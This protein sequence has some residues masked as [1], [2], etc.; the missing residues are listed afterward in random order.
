MLKTLIRGA[1]AACVMAAVAA[2]ASAEEKVNYMLPAPAVLPAFA[3][4]MLAKYLG[5]Y[6]AEGFDV[7]FQLGR[8]GLDVGRQVGVGN[9]PVGGGLGDTPIL[10]R[11]SGVPV[12]AVAVL[13]GGAM[14]VIV[15]RADRGIKTL[16][17]LKGKAI[18][19]LSFQDTT[20]FA[21]LGSLASV[22]LGSDDLH[23]QAVGP[24]GTPGLVIAGKADAC[25]CVP[26]WEIMVK[27]ALDGK[28]V[29]MPSLQYFPS[30]AQAILASDDLIK[31]QPKLVAGL[32]RATLKGMKYIMDDPDKAAA[33]YVKAVP[34]HAGKEKLMAEI[35]RNFVERTY[36]GQKTLGMIDPKRMAA[37]QD[38]YLKKKIISKATPIADLYTNDFVK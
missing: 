9:V 16:K 35:L 33:D 20:Y 26:D 6:K 4:W 34:A 14:M 28:I 30:M 29:S 15:A 1:V 38:F 23:I 27:H 17:D 37:V 31:K 13:G 11:A 19:T 22:G 3:P 7:T 8:G 21:L 12:K 24:R 32:V 5:Y 2:P 10:V 36:K 18:T 25:A